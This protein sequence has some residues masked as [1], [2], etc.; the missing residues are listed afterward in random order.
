[1]MGFANSCKNKWI[2]IWLKL[3]E[4][5]S[6]SVLKNVFGFIRW[7]LLRSP[8]IRYKLCIMLY[9]VVLTFGCMDETLVWPFQWEILSSTFIWYCL[10]SHGFRQTRDLIGYQREVFRVELQGYCWLESWAKTVAIVKTK[11]QLVLEKKKHL[12]EFTKTANLKNWYL[13][14]RFAIRA[15]SNF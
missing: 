1:M 3:N 2:Y 9:K 10:E 5:R 12:N 4:K 6:P 14:H 7:K 8:F 15:L 13:T 11:M